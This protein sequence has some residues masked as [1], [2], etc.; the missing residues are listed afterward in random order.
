MSKFTIL[1]LAAITLAACAGPV[2]TAAPRAT[3][4]TPVRTAVATARLPQ[5]P[6]SAS[7][8]LGTAKPSA[9]PL[10]APTKAA[11]IAVP[12]AVASATAAP[13]GIVSDAKPHLERFTGGLSRPTDLTAEPSLPGH[14]YVLEQQG[15]IRVIVD[16]RL[17]PEAMLDIQDRVGSS[18]NEQGLLGMAFSP[19]YAATR[20]FFVN[21]TN[22]D[23]DT[24]VSRFTASDDGLSA[25]PLSELIVLEVDQPYANHNGGQI[26]FGPDGMLYIGMGDGGSGGDPRNYAQNSSSRLGKMLRIDVSQATFEKPYAIPPDNPSFGPNSLPELWAIGLRNPWR[27]SF[28]RTTG[29]LFIADV[30]QGVVEEINLQPANRAGDN[31]GWRLREGLREYSG[32]RSDYFVEP[33]HEYEHDDSCSV[34]G[35]YVYR[36]QTLNALKGAYVYGDFCSGKIWTLRREGD[37]WRNAV[38]EETDLSITSFGED[39]AGELYVLDRAGAV[40]RF[41]P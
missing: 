1:L 36:G 13:N 11:A 28:D 8:T 30:G 17:R 29:D 27:F 4:V 18:G 7:A 40:Y 33:I 6:V 41:E 19:A 32:A 21:Y 12:T 23:G 24:V 39:A 9:T 14:L 20:Y 37:R 35:G 16:G 34:T 2:P 26:K 38:L 25:D 5:T 10:A 3:T 15:R 31:Y 22:G